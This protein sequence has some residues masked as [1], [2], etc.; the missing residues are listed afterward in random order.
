MKQFFFV[1]RIVTIHHAHFDITV[2][3]QF[4]PNLRILFDAAT[5]S[6]LDRDG[7]LTFTRHSGFHKVPINDWHGF[8]SLLYSYIDA[9]IEVRKK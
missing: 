1:F 8:I 5:P 2:L 4:K 9:N 7:D 3:F 6:D